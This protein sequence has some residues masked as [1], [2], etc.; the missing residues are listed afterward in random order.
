[1]HERCHIQRRDNVTAAVHMVAEPMFWFYPVVWWI[2]SRLVDERERACD[3]EV[4]RTF[5]EPKTYAEGIVNV[6]KRYVEMPLACGSGVSGANVKNRISDILSNRTLAKLSAA[7]KVVLAGVG[8][9]A[10][11]A[12]TF[13]QS[14]PRPPVD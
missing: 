1:M 12:P 7:Q 4:V 10:V 13:A 3:Q 5:G 9:I 11:I 8:A 14:V 6:C 2:G